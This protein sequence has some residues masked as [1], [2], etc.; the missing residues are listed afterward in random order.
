MTLDWFGLSSAILLLW[1]PML[2]RGN[3][4]REIGELVRWQ[5][6]EPMAMLRLWPNWVD[7]ARAALGTWVLLT[8]TFE[9]DPNDRPQRWAVF[10]ARAGI[11]AAG[12]AAQTIR[13]RRVLYFMA[14]VFYLSGVTLVLSDGLAGI[15]GVCVSWAFAIALKNGQYVLPVMTV[16]LGLGTMVLSNIGVVLFLNE[17]L[18]MI[19]LLLGVLFL[20]GPRLLD[21]VT[22]M[23]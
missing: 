18:L 19:P 10:L 16:A 17:S 22:N 4:P 6:A 1:F 14:P 23:P 9:F 7:L 11:L 3:A 8:T 12:V 2:A 20:R 13:F 15:F 5:P 21:S